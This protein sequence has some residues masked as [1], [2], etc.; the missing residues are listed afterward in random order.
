M[1][2]LGRHGFQPSQMGPET[3]HHPVG[4]RGNHE[5]SRGKSRPGE[6]L[7]GLHQD[8]PGRSGV[9]HG[10]NGLGQ[11]DVT[12]LL[13]GRGQGAVI[14]RGGGFGEKHIKDDEAGPC[15]GQSLNQVGMEA[16]G[17]GPG[18]AQFMEGGLVDAHDEEFGR[19][20]GRMPQTVAKVQGLVLQVLAQGKQTQG[21]NDGQGRQRQQPGS[22]RRTGEELRN[23]AQV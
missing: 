16:P 13:H 19:G 18:P 5:Q 1:E 14:L 6:N 8:L 11:D 23:R 9:F 2:H 10:F 15:L 17:P 22:G 4:I 7:Q 3:A 20:R 12:G 21:R